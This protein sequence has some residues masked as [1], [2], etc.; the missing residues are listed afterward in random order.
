VCGRGVWDRVT[1]MDDSGSRRVAPFA[2][3]NASTASDPNAIGIYDAGVVSTGPRKSSYT[4]LAP[5][6]DGALYDPMTAFFEMAGMTSQSLG[7]QT[8]NYAS[9]AENEK[10]KA[11][12]KLTMHY[13]GTLQGSGF[14]FDSSIRRGK[15]FSF[16]VGKGSVIKGWDEGV[17]GMCVGEKRTLTVPHS[18]GYGSDDR[19][20]IPPYST[21]IFDI[22]LLGIK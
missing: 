3:R 21:L 15:P 10:A 14:E 7:I 12:D 5:R 18:L 4:A 20:K 9:C 13:T 17:V 6:P 19:P 2:C 11:G 16:V 22:E 8:T 1:S